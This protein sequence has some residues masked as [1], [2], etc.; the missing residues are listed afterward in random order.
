MPH[1]HRKKTR[2]VK[3]CL[4]VGLLAIAA[5]IG[6]LFGPS[7][8][9]LA[10]G[11][12]RI[13]PLADNDVGALQGK[14]L[15]ADL[16]TLVGCYAET[17][18]RGYIMPVNTPGATIYIGV[19]LPKSKLADA[20]AVVAD[21]QR[22]VNDAD[23]S[24]RWD[25][26]RVTVRGTLQPMD[27]ETETQFR[28]YLREAGF[29]DDEIGPDDTCTFRPL[30]LTDG[31]INGRINARK[32]YAHQTVH[33]PFWLVILQG[34]LCLLGF[35]GKGDH[36]AVGLLAQVVL[37][38]AGVFGGNIRV[39]AQCHKKSGQLAVAA[40]DALCDLHT[41]LLQLDKT[42][43]VHRNIPVL[44][45]IFHRHTDTRLGESHRNG[46]VDGAHRTLLLL[47]H[48]NF[49]QIVLCGFVNVHGQSPL[50]D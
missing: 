14:Y 46:Y 49:F 23:G 11:P 37:D 3:R 17:A 15:E 5:A 31:K 22:M 20:D 12:T 10:Q 16:D 41:G 28:A 45:Q 21:T 4:A 13:D 27:A 25:G 40:I 32:R 19:E 39:N 36:L 1:S 43:R 42:V 7:A 9:V 29:G 30:V 50:P 35:F 47:Q 44:T 24:Y 48:Q 18:P 6:V 34:L 26:S 38:L 33:M 2:A 8:L